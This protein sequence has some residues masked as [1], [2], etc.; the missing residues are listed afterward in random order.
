MCLL[1]DPRNSSH[2]ASTAALQTVDQAALPNIR[3]A[4]KRMAD[5]SVQEG[6]SGTSGP[7]CVW[8]AQAGAMT[9]T[10]GSQNQSLAS[11]LPTP[12][13]EQV[14]TWPFYPSPPFVNTLGQCVPLLGVTPPTYNQPGKGAQ[15]KAFV[16]GSNRGCTSGSVHETENYLYWC[17]INRGGSSSP[18]VRFSEQLSA[19][20][21]F[22][23]GHL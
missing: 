11:C 10:Q 6:P 13:P 14:S 23:F 17:V 7:A 4:Y 18:D 22:L 21:V 5:G 15:C 16:T 1:G 9:R 2:T 19:C 12:G 20:S 8:E 3:K